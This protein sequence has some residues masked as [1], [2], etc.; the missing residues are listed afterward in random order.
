VPIAER[1]AEAMSMPEGVESIPGDH[2]VGVHGPSMDKTHRNDTSQSDTESDV[3]LAPVVPLVKPKKEIQPIVGLD[4]A[5]EFLGYDGDKGKQAF[6]KAR[7]R[8]TKKHGESIPGEFKVGGYP[9]WWPKDLKLWH[10]KLPRT[11]VRE[12]EAATK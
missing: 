6:V 11:G 9:A 12:K 1:E 2:L 4:Q 10:A 3:Y 8:Y 5:A 7:Y